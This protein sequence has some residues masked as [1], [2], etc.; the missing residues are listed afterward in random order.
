VRTL[1]GSPNPSAQLQA[2]PMQHPILASLA[3]SAVLIA[4]F[5]P[6]SAHLFRKKTVG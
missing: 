6:L 5:A 2:W 1:F 4:I 3:W